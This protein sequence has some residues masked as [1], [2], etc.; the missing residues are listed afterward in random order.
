MNHSSGWYCINIVRRNSLL[1][2]CGNLR[3]KWHKKIIWNGPKMRNKS[4]M[5]VKQNISLYLW[6]KRWNGSSEL[7]IRCKSS[8]LEWQNRGIMNNLFC[9][10]LIGYISLK[11]PKKKTINCKSWGLWGWS[12]NLLWD[13]FHLNCGLKKFWPGK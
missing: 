11:E 7:N 5:V 3:V 12:L 1:I 8:T 2:N 9:S 4:W 13:K 10:N 6:P